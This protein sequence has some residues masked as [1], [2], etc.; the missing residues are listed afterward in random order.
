[1]IIK[2]FLA[3]LTLSALLTGWI[4][5]ARAE[6]IDHDGEQDHF[7][8]LS[9]G[10]TAPEDGY[11]FN[12]AALSQVIAKQETKLKELSIVK[13]TEI[14]KIQL[15]LETVTKKKDAEIQ[16]NKEMNDSLLKIKQ[17]RI[18]QLVSDQKWS[19]WKLVGG[20]V[21]GFAASIAMFYAA[22]QVA[23]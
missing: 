12:A 10:D 17:D 1:M 6:D 18:D 15:E 21:L 16:I 20:F 19:D 13:E 4:P 3:L 9:T 7:V 2:K 22:V 5:I 23:K 8:E 14:K 11:F